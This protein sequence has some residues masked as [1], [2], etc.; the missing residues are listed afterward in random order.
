MTRYTVVWVKSAQDEL[1]DAWLNSPNRGAVTEAA[2]W[3]DQELAEDASSKGHE[4]HE[5]LRAFFSPP[6]RILYEVRESD[7]TVEVLRVK[8][9]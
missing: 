7:R 6:L 5:G 9:L 1:A 2:H 3:I 4:V 8:R